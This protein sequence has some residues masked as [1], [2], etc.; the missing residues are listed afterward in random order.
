MLWYCYVLVWTCINCIVYWYKHGLSIW[1]SFFALPDCDFEAIFGMIFLER[2]QAGYGTVALHPTNNV[3]TSGSSSGEVTESWWWCSTAGGFSFCTMLLCMARVRP[4]SFFGTTLRKMRHAKPLQLMQKFRNAENSRK[5]WMLRRRRGMSWS[6]KQKFLLADALGV[7]RLKMFSRHFV[8]AVTQAPPTESIDE[9]SVP[10]MKE[11]CRILYGNGHVKKKISKKRFAQGPLTG[12]PAKM[13]GTH[14]STCR[15]WPERFFLKHIY[16]TRP[17]RKFP[18]IMNLWEK[19]SNF[20][21]PLNYHG[22][23]ALGI[24]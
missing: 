18:T 11:L 5:A 24:L 14:F 13:L 8:S 22:A 3:T 16:R 4:N 2:Q 1:R 17:W 23:V 6:W 21:P 19:M 7:V 12:V 9:T 15:I 20:D 10:N